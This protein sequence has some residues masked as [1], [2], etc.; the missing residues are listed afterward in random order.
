MTEPLVGRDRELAAVRGLFQPGPAGE[1]VLVLF[2]EL[3]SGKTALFEDAVGNAAARGYRVVRAGGVQAETRFA[4]GGLQR[5]AAAIRPEVGRLPPRLRDAL[6][7][8]L[9]TTPGGD[10]GPDPLLAGAALAEALTLAVRAQPML[11]AIDD[12]Q[13]LDPESLRTVAFAARRSR[14]APLAM[15]FGTDEH[16]AVPGWYTDLPQL[17]LAP[18]DDAAAGR[19]LDRLPYRLS[20]R[21]RLEVIRQ[22]AGNP[23]ALTE[24]AAAPL[25]GALDAP[26][27]L[28]ERLASVFARRLRE[29]PSATRHAL[30]LAAADPVLA[31]AVADPDVWEPAVRLGFVR[32]AT[33][34][35]LFSHPLVSAAAYQDAALPDRRGAHQALADATGAPP[36]R[37]AWHLALAAAGPD[38]P[39]AAGLEATALDAA[40]RGG[41]SSA[42]AA[43]ERAADL[44]PD[45]V[46]RARRLR[47]AAGSAL[48]A[49]HSDWTLQLLADAGG[50]CGDAAAATEASLRRGQALLIA[51]R[52]G[53]AYNTLLDASAHLPDA[54]GL[55]GQVRATLALVAYYS[56]S[57][58]HRAAARGLLTGAEGWDDP[59]TLWSA[60][61]LDPVRY[62]VAAAEHLRSLVP[63]N[64]TAPEHLAGLATVAWLADETRIAVDLFDE[65][66]ARWATKGPVPDGLGCALSMAYFEAG[67]WQDATRHACEAA[68][69]ARAASLPA[70]AAAADALLALF[71]A[72]RGDADDAHSLALGALQVLDQAPSAAAVRA[73][74]SLGAA[75][76]SEG[77]YEEAWEWY[78]SLFDAAGAPLHYHASLTHL[79][80]LAA[81]ATRS[82]RGRE[83]AGILA[84]AGT[85]LADDGSARMRMLLVHARALIAADDAASGLFEQ[86]ESMSDS[87]QR[88]YEAARVFLDY[89]SWLRRIRRV[90]AARSRLRSAVTLFEQTG[91]S[92]WAV[93]AASEL[94]AAG[95]DGLPAPQPAA[96]DGLSPQQREI[97]LLAADGYTNQEIADQLVISARTVSSHLY[98]A[99]P[100]LGVSSRGQLRRAFNAS[101]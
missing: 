7:G 18:L 9:R 24:F 55:A 90:T 36:D 27:P 92:R 2:G 48:L 31:V 93:K 5:L 39:V 76:L 44:T 30:V 69:A 60:V 3:G 12:A 20:P 99:F 25:G 80:G 4:F 42:A 46:T 43:L 85:V 82:G 50:V 29:L 47:L 65:A 51:Q 13:W 1:R 78:R 64:R 16:R 73:R 45:P 94:R 37:R 19:L 21:H 95:S 41:H 35:I 89:G 52:Y 71:A 87:A 15:L 33:G 88:P 62:A 8:V 101:Q 32:A 59:G 58:E 67:R 70:L 83:A 49:G 57:Y 84:T 22:A 17:E 26:L 74:A 34:R 98:R 53:A 79:P 28:D 91:A 86:A 77:G 100:K 40:G 96:L 38:E 75:A 14:D 6:I 66:A 10:R 81:A 23:L 97:V 54:G 11:L 63:A 68:A 61:V 56:G 72:A